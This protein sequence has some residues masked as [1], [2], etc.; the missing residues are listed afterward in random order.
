M[1][2]G[3]ARL[4]LLLA[5]CGYWCGGWVSCAF[6]ACPCGLRVALVVAF[7]E[8]RCLV[9]VG[10]HVGVRG[11]AA[12]RVVRC[13]AKA[14]ACKLM[15]ADGRPTPHFASLADGEAFLAERDAAQR[16]GFTVR[17]VG[18]SER[19]REYPTAGELSARQM[20][21]LTAPMRDALEAYSS[22]AALDVNKYLKQP[23]GSVLFDENDGTFGD[24]MAD[25]AGDPDF[26][27]FDDDDDVFGDPDFGGFADGDLFGDYESGVPVSLREEIDAG[28]LTVQKAD[29]LIA[30]MDEAFS[31]APER[32]DA[33]R[34]LYRGVQARVN[35]SG[36]HSTG[37]KV[38]DA[39]VG[40]VV[41]FPEYLST[42]TSLAVADDFSDSDG[43][44]LTVMEIRTPRGLH[45][46]AVSTHAD[47]DECLLPRNMRLRMVSVRRE[48]TSD[49]VV[50]VVKTFEDASHSG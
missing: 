7:F 14:G 38:A 42:S 12:G 32:A 29:R 26:G 41:V 20:R 17:A 3:V 13:S 19:T 46:S 18:G 39:A 35:Y 44:E 2:V 48:E 9:V 45:M 24:M 11:K 8:G 49:G 33:D 4:L 30:L 36:A 5:W 50:R 40:D 28:G 31:S 23:D 37:G 25:L 1:W 22:S 16:G 34:P 21:A 47:E 15:G 27:G 10:F 6:G 43:S